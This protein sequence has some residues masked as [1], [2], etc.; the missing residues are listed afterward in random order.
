[1]VLVL[2][3]ALLLTVPL[4]PAGASRAKAREPARMGTRL[5]SF[6]KRLQGRLLGKALPV[7]A[8]CGLV[9]TSALALALLAPLTSVPAAIGVVGC[10]VVFPAA[11]LALQLLGPPGTH[12][13]GTMRGEPAGAELVA[14]ARE[15]AQAVGVAPPKAVYQLH[16]REPNAFACGLRHNTAVAVTSGLVDA[17]SEAELKAVLA[18]EMGHLKHGDVSRNMHVAI[19]AAGLGGVYSAGQALLTR[20]HEIEDEKRRRQAEARARRRAAG[21]ETEADAKDAADEEDATRAVSDQGP[22]KTI[23][24]VLIAGGACMQGVAH[25]LRLAASRVAELSADRAAA[26]AFGAGALISALEKIH[27]QS[28]QHD[29]LRSSAF[30]AQLAHAMISDGPTPPA[31]PEAVGG[32]HP[33][34]DGVSHFDRLVDR[35]LGLLRTHPPLDV[36]VAALQGAGRE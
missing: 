2:V 9:G 3:C 23:A 25:L 28:A 11:S 21:A 4:V 13:L 30:G 19:A 6:A 8:Y 17:L 35:V 14:L 31:E 22:L 7:L 5:L 34:L 10:A 33:G 12:V 24:R 16:A 26:D 36:R 18:H 15:A 27:E 32:A 20:A 1:M 29:D